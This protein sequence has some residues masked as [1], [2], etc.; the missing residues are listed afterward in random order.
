[1]QYNYY[2]GENYAVNIVEVYCK[3]AKGSHPQYQWF[4]NNT[5]LDDLS[6]LY[7]VFDHHL[8]QSIL[9]LYVDWSPTGTYH[10][11]A[12]DSFDNI[13][14]ISSKKQFL[15][16][17]GTLD[18]F[19][20]IQVEHPWHRWHLTSPPPPPHPSAPPVLNHL[21]VLVVAV[22]FGCF[23]FLVL[24][25]SV[26]CGIGVVYSE[27]TV[28]LL[29]S[30][31]SRCSC[32]WLFLLFFQGEGSMETSLCESISLLN[33]DILKFFKTIL[34]EA[35]TSICDENLS[36]SEFPFYFTEEESHRPTG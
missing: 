11:E 7:V 13:T 29:F 31:T 26:C 17:E 3:A 32:D 18:P 23:T 34:N 20:F 36:H 6:N 10:C 28:Y 15:D 8:Q 33:S 2:L 1:M 4:L 19:W 9:V 5:R 25:V 14:A 21:P 12:S 16:K 30:K 24:L 22:V 35:V 27:F